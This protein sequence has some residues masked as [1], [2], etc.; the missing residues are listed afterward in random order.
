M[1]GALTVVPALLVDARYRLPV[2][3][4]ELLL[5]PALLPFAIPVMCVAKAA[6]A[7][8]RYRH[9]RTGGA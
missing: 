2:R 5:W 7:A 6:L 1:P 9:R 3:L 4:H 8:L